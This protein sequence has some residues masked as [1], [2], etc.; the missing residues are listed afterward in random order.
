[1]INVFD[2][3]ADDLAES[4]FSVTDQFLSQQE[5]QSILSLE[6]FQNALTEFKQAGIGQNHNLQVNEAVR[7]DY[8]QW[9]D[10]TTAVE[11]LQMYTRRLHELLNHL[12]Q[13]L[14]L[15]L[16]DIEVH[17]TVYPAGAFYK[18]HLDQFKQDDH[19]KLSVICYL[20]QDWNAFHGGELRMHLENGPRDFLPIAGRLICFRSDQIEHEV[21]PATRERLSLT[22]WMLDQISDLRHL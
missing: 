12:N 3:I 4:G 19:R 10:K 1:M 2:K 9:I 17:M 11:P 7:G 13:S 16:K 8:I 22:G 20:N 6:H 21:L 15:S 14:F 18:R 5:V